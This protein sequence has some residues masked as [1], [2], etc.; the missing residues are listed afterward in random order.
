LQ[1][2][3]VDPPGYFDQIVWPQ[4]ALWN[5]HLIDDARRDPS[6][7]VLNTD[8]TTALDMTTSAIYEIKRNAAF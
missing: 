5:G 1:G 6:I 2:Y 7:H 8:D 3:W 4:F